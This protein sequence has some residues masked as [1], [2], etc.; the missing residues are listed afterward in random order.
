MLDDPERYQ[1][2]KFAG[3]RVRM[4]EAIVEY[5]DRVPCGIVRLVY[6]MLRF[7]AQGRLDL[8]AFERQNVALAGLIV[9]SVIGESTTNDVVVDASSRFIAKG[10]QWEPSPSLA[11]QIRGAALGE[12]KC[13][14]L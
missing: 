1:M 6:E 9:D 5:R 7:D 3:Q 2:P 8:G 12:L 14:R 13:K 4:V 11:R 10:G